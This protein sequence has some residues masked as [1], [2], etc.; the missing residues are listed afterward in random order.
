MMQK[1]KERIGGRVSMSWEKEK[2]SSA[3]DFSKRLKMLYVTSFQATFGIFREVWVKLMSTHRF[4]WHFHYYLEVKNSLGN[5]YP[6]HGVWLSHIELRINKYLWL[7]SCRD[8]KIRIRELLVIHHSSKSCYMP[9]EIV[10]MRVR[11]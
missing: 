5:T 11:G 8:Y 3:R 1:R 4:L 9:R 10:I 2:G 7:H 6:L